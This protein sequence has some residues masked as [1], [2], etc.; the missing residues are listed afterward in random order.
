MR[1]EINYQINES[2]FKKETKINYYRNKMIDIYILNNYLDPMLNWK[3]DQWK[4][5]KR[6]IINLFS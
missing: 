5:E 1:I 3:T 4:W 6:H 2:Y